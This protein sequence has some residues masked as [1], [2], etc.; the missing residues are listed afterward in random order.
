VVAV[1]GQFSHRPLG[2]VNPL[3]YRLLGTRALHD[4]VAP[5]SP[6]ADVSTFYVNNL[7][8]TQ[9]KIFGLQTIDVQSS[10]LHDTPG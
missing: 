5:A 3:L 1:A 8:N 10:T 9:G 2:F 6:L 7:D 4:I